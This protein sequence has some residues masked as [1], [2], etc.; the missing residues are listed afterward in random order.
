ML[1]RP[2]GGTEKQ[3]VAIDARESA[4]ASTNE[5]MYHNRTTDYFG[6]AHSI[7]IRNTGCPPPPPKV[8]PFSV[9]L[10]FA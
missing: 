9:R 1:C 5:S 4:P 3:M 7:V 2:R 8:A 10:N 6:T